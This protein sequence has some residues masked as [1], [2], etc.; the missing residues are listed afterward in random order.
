[1]ILRFSSSCPFYT[2]DFACAF[3]GDLQID[4]DLFSGLF[5]FCSF[6]F[7]IITSDIL[8]RAEVSFSSVVGFR[9]KFSSCVFILS[10]GA[11][12]WPPF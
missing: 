12:S 9:P 6:L 8:L 7:L 4:R 5:P 1:M 3:V 11:D 10:Y 2:G